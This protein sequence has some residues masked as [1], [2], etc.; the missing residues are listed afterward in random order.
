[1][2]HNPSCL[3]PA[4][5]QKI[6]FD[7]PH[8]ARVWNYWLGGKDNYPVDQAAGEA[9]KASH[10]QIVDHVGLVRRFVVNTVG[11]LA[12]SAGVRQFLDIGTR[13]PH[14]ASR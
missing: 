10:P 3:P 12:G 11:Y 13:L 8:S 1:V 2:T 4:P 9:W 6:E 5:K 14:S 7:V